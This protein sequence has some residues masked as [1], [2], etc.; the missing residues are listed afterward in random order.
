[1]TLF[2][3][4][5]RGSVRSQWIS[6]AVHMAGWAQG[7]LRCRPV[8]WLA[9]PA[10]TQESRVLVLDRKPGAAFPLLLSCWFAPTDGEF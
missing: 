9:L 6:R 7:W 5:G 10:R 4:T 8:S 2:L 1:M 3:L